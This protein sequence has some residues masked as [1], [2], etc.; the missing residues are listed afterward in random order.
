MKDLRD[1]DEFHFD[2]IIS[3]DDTREASISFDLQCIDLA[4]AKGS[5]DRM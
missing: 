4:G 3:A 5:A 1:F 2:L